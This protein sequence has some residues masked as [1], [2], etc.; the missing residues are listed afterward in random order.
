MIRVR[1]T[2]AGFVWFLGISETTFDEGN[3]NKAANSIQYT[4]YLKKMLDLKS[5]LNSIV[6][7]T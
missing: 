3:I 2:M 1:P 6:I 7:N 4:K 5:A